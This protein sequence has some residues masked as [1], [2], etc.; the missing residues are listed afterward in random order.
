MSH[1]LNKNFGTSH[2]LNSLLAV[3]IAKTGGKYFKA[4]P[5]SLLRVQIFSFLENVGISGLFFFFNSHPQ[6][7]SLRL[8]MAWG[9]WQDL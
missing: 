1:P 2:R 8:K 5:G 9:I 6:V 4:N 3:G 7:F